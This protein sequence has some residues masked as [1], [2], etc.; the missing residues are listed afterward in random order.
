MINLMYIILA[1]LGL[2]FL[3]FIHELGHYF[4]GRKVGMKVEVFSIGFGRPFHVWQWQGV[5]WQLCILP[6][7]GYVRF[8]GMEKKGALEP[9][10]IPEGFFGKKPLDRIKVAL[11]GPLVNIVF[12]LF[13]FAL[14]WLAGGRFK[15][16]SSYTQIIGWLDPSSKLAE[17]G[18]K[19]GDQFLSIDGTKIQN[20]QDLMYGVVFSGGPLTLKADKVDYW[21]GQKRAFDV[22]F[23]QETKPSL[24][25]KIT[26]VQ[27]IV[28]ASFLLYDRYQN[29]SENTIEA[30]SPMLQSGIKYG[31][32]IVWAD[33]EI[34][35]SQSQLSSII[36]QPR[37]LLTVKR[38]EEIFLARV[39]RLEL[40]DVQ[41]RS[42]EKAEL[43]DRRIEAKISTRLSNLFIIPYRLSS[44]NIVETPLTYIDE[45]SKHCV[46]FN[47]LEQSSCSP[48]E[49]P[50]MA[51]DKIL[52]V[53]GRRVSDVFES[54]KALQERKVLIAVSTQELKKPM[55][56]KEGDSR[57]IHDIDWIQLKRMVGSIGT[58]S[59]LP[60]SGN[61]RFLEPV[62]PR[63]L[64]DFPDSKNKAS[65]LK[66]QSVAKRQID[67]I[68][69]PQE[70]Q[71]ANLSLELAQKKLRLGLILQDELVRYNPNPFSLF[72]STLLQTWATLK[73]LLT[74]TISP[75]ALSGPVAMVQVM[76]YGWEVGMKEALYWMGLISLNLGIFNLLPIPVLDGG[77]ICFA[78]WEAITKKPIKAKT[79]ERLI[80]PFIVALVVLLVFTTYQ[81]L[82]RLFR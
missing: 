34:I 72:G 6:F 43:D 75:K 67:K 57:F 81:D 29:G 13:V 16:F 79:M 42:E 3:I 17:D 62:T 78:L 45:N 47:P 50:L 69:N 54:L 20:L 80:I 63:P 60:L 61:L 14:L 19:A 55:L 8:A 74:G 12:A 23:S 30:G 11:M 76:H 5:K 73:G 44:D 68:Q 58:S 77:H 38:G 52:A 40:S 39:P 27:S 21:T 48:L 32:R 36:N 15:P 56:W 59:F 28:P 9:H 66:G 2:G 49:K 53:D 64:G 51:N 70:K 71:R 25:Q 1:L 24:E 65:W 31:D 35:F 10:Q 82:L 41:L 26:E 46:S 37:V 7:G 18:L 33:G 22:P 4:M